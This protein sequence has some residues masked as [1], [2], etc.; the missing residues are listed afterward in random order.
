MNQ[1]IDLAYRTWRYQGIV[2]RLRAFE[3]DSVTR[4]PLS[5]SIAMWRRGFMRRSLRMYRLD[6][7]GIDTR[8]YLTDFEREKCW[9]IGRNHAPLVEDKQLFERTFGPLLRVPI[10]LG[11][12]QRGTLRSLT[13]SLGVMNEVS[14]I[15]L[16]E[17]GL[18]PDGVVIKPVGG[19]GGHG[20]HVVRRRDDGSFT[21]NLEPVSPERLASTTLAEGSL[22]TEFIRQSD[23]AS[24]LH[25]PS[26]NTIRIITMI[27][28]DNQEAFV[29]RAV[30]RIGSASTG[31]ID[32]YS[33]GGLAVQIDEETGR[34]GQL[35]RFFPREELEILDA[36]PDTGRSVS[37]EFVPGWHEITKQ[38]LSVAEMFPQLPYLGWD[39]VHTPSGFAAIE[40]N[41][42]TGV[43]ML[44]VERPLIHNERIRR[45]YTHHRVLAGRNP[46]RWGW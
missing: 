38:L 32:N 19:G 31:P 43:G 5:K 13:R 46:L 24:S 40:A 15:D 44:Q 7:A 42:C 25:E 2:R 29:A 23:W 12:V 22:V 37:G 1:V 27:D 35:T 17:S 45:F 3:R 4:L 8:A 10:N 36:H 18:A 20:V 6:R 11:I 21:W 26:T 39:L 14:L 16:L 9:M 30:Q 41:A 33:R 28:P 34:L